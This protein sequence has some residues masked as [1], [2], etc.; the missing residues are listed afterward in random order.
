M[1]YTK[2]LLYQ[3]NYW[4][5]EGLKKAKIRDLSGAAVSL[6]KSLQYN[7]VNIQ[8]RNLLGLVYY[9]RGEV[10]EALVEW[11]ISKHLKS[12]DNIANYY[13]KAIQDAPGELE[14]INQAVKKYN[15]CLTY[16]DQGG[17]DLAI[18]QLK[19]ITTVHTSFL[20]AHQL[21]AL[22]YMH[23]D[24]YAK[25]K[26]V[27]RRAYKIDTKN[28]MTLRYVQELNK[29]SAAKDTK[30]KDTKGKEQKASPAVYQTRK[31]TPIQPVSSAL[32]E[33]G[34]LNI[35]NM[36]IGVII[37]AAVVWFLI[38]PA[39]AKTK[40][41]Q[42]N[43]SFRQYSEKMEA[44]SAQISA[45]QKE[46]DEY[47]N[48]SEQAEASKA[49]MQAMKSSYEAVLLVKEQYRSGEYSNATMAETLKTVKAD[50][51]G[52]KAAEL[53][54]ELAEDI[55]DPLCRDAY[56]EAEESYDEEDYASAIT[57]L[58]EVIALRPGYKD[59]KALLMLGNAYAKNNEKEKASEAYNRILS[60]YPDGD[61]AQQAKDA[62]A[63]LAGTPETPSGGNAPSTDEN[64]PTTDEDTSGEDE[65]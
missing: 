12:Q 11:I 15:Q 7:R 2:K 5:N 35:L 33:N 42:S 50:T 53:Y 43:E 1:T 56:S 31:D 4:Y 28:E 38:M 34:K 9:G 49:D 6:R 57:L 36:V 52:E 8:A 47:R 48:K 19:K 64:S 21:L 18:I 44:Q 61:I 54:N 25:A 16:C 13:V 23:T 51:L 37:G 60:L 30:G 10:A 39:A 24:Q 17:E 45:L 32:R 26:Q 55:F 46:L 27:L 22:L 62:A 3:S 14:A 65:E 58:N 29:V 20:K 63:E 41:E 59:G 40:T